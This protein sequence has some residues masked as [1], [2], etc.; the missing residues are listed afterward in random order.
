MNRYGYLLTGVIA[1]SMLIMN[2]NAATG[3]I[4]A[5]ASS[6]TITVGSTVTV[7][8]K[9]S[10]SDALGSWQFGV[11]YDSQVLSLVSG[12]TT[13]ASYGDG[14][15]KVKSYTYKFKAIKSGTGKVSIN[16]ASMV[17]WNDDSTLFTPSTN[18]VSITAK[19]QAEIEASYSKDNYLKALSVEGYEISPAFN[20]ETLEYS[21]VV[22]DNIEE[23]KIN[24]SVNDSRST[25]SGVGTVSIIEGVSKQEITVRA[26]NGTV[27]TYILNIDVKD[28]NPINVKIDNEE[29]L[30]V[31]KEE[32]LTAPNGYEKT[33]IMIND[34][35]VPALKNTQ[36]NF[37][38]VGLKNNQGSVSL[39]KYDEVKKEYSKYIEIKGV[40]ITVYP[41]DGDENTPEGF[42][43]S[44]LK[45]NDIETDVYINDINSNIIILYGMN[46]ETGEKAFYQYDKDANTI[47]KY[48]E[49]FYQ[50]VTNEKDEYK[51]LTIL[52][53]AMSLVLLIISILEKI[54][55]SKLKKLLIKF[56]NKES[57][58]S[59]PEVV[60][61]PVNEN[62]EK[63]EVSTLGEAIESELKKEEE[64]TSTI[65]EESAKEKEIELEKAK[66]R[67]KK[68]K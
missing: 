26:Q 40:S 68:K 58:I 33:K 47:T 1:S 37:I 2:T 41:I 50:K 51:L 17:S 25:V 36:T 64:Q 20:K 57:V 43:K 3:S 56:S 23:I 19:T 34:I 67:R 8:V 39:Y 14:S 24:A 7:T 65:L 53:G 45:I 61:P 22:P 9:V 4:T 13:V 21:V 54:K 52:F 27:R 12:D 28:L 55:I 48:N 59:K 6:Q 29:Y 44:K 66:S 16:G 18:S 5:S 11:S 35:E 46:T 60:V 63:E 10:C 49:S 62:E 31:K 30:V 42:T 38:L 15:T 32:L